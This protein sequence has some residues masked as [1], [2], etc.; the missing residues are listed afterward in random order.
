MPFTEYVGVNRINGPF[1]L[2][3]AIPGAGY[4]E[5]VDVIPPSGEVRKG[6]V[7]L[8]DEKSTLVQVFSGTEGLVPSSTA[9]RFLGRELEISLSPSLLGRTFNGLGEPRDGCGPVLGG[10]AVP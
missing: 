6:R 8:V 2:L 7:V 10:S 1:L 5:I 3:S 9:V 4:D